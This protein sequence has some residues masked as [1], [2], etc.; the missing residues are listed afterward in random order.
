LEGDVRREKSMVYKNYV[1]VV[2]EKEGGRW[3]GEIRRKDGQEMQVGVSAVRTMYA[4]TAGEAMKLARKAIDARA[5]S[6]SAGWA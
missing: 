4:S 2:V 5:I 6:R 3:Q 1:I